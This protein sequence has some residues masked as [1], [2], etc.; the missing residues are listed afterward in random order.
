MSPNHEPGLWQS[1]KIQPHHRDRLAIVY[2][3]HST[4]QQVLEVF[5]H[6]NKNY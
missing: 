5:G 2:V 1:E 3:R 4:L 6:S